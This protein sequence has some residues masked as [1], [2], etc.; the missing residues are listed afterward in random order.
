MTTKICVVTG[1]SSGIGL[2]TA[3]QLALKQHRVYAVARRHDRLETL[4]EAFP[5]SIQ[6][7]CADLSSQ[8]GIA[9]LTEAVSKERQLNCVLHAA[10]SSTALADYSELNDK[11]ILD[12]MAVHIAAPITI[13]N[14][15][16][17]Q[18]RGCRILYID[19]YSASTP[20]VG[21]AGYSIV[22]AAAQMAARSAAAELQHATVIRVFPGGVRTPLVKAILNSD[23]D[24]DV[25]RVFKAMD[26]AGELSE[27]ETIGAF[28]ASILLDASDQQLAERESWDFNATEQPVF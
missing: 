1:A 22:K 4:K 20:R 2:A 7:V 14:R 5:A 24:S 3:R 17:P 21:W 11:D 10:A 16:R 12:D 19:S 15:L 26:A 27:P 28:I 6:P 13:N 23:R 18:L 8:S 9:R 25:V